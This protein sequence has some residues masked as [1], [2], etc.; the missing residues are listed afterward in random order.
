MKPV[1]VPFFISHQGCPHTCIFC[2]QR[3][4][5]GS[6]GS[7]PSSEEMLGK[8]ENWR[9]TAGERPL[10]V[11]FFGGSFTALPESTQAGLLDPLQMLLSRGIITSVRLST[12]P[13]YIDDRRVTWLAGMGVQT[14][15][16]GVQ[17]MDDCVLAASGRGHTA[18]ESEKAILCIKKHDLAAGAQLMPGLPGD[19]PVSSCASLERVISAGVDFIR[20]YPTVVL[21][22]TELARR[23]DAGNFMPLSLQRGVSL[24]K[25]LLQ[26]AMRAGVNV[27]RIGLQA[28]ERLNQDSVLAGCWHPSLGQLVRSQLYGDLLCQM[29]D[30]V[31]DLA[32][33]VV[34]CHSK[35]LSDVMGLAKSNLERYQLKDRIAAVVAASGVAEEELIVEIMP[36]LPHPHPDHPL[37][38]EGAL[39]AFLPFQGGDQE[40]DENVHQSQVRTLK[41]NIITD[42]H[43]S[44]HEV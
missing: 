14:I 9:L 34:K 4:I 19:T 24:C 44:I 35:H 22:G 10:E 5:S 37:E 6:V 2:D 43:Y 41:G 33:V 42:L 26:R 23:Y 11:A 18:A 32:P 16:L 8:I 3:L 17:S 38:G 20:I 40:G 21:R 36:F 25:M 39:S 27:I 12:R 13:D 31:P 28:D 15:E 29:I 30:R 1:T 7:L